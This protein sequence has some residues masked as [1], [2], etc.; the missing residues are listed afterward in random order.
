[1]WLET[2]E[3]EAARRLRRRGGQKGEDGQYLLSRLMSWADVGAF[4]SEVPKEQWYLYGEWV[5]MARSHAAQSALEEAIANKKGFLRPGC[6]NGPRLAELT[7]ALLGAGYPH[8]SPRLTEGTVGTSKNSDEEEAV[9]LDHKITKPGRRE[10]FF[11][12]WYRAVRYEYTMHASRP[13]EAHHNF[14][15]PQKFVYAVI[16]MAKGIVEDTYARVTPAEVRAAASKAAASH[17]A[18]ASVENDVQ[19]GKKR[20]FEDA[21]CH[22][23]PF[24]RDVLYPQDGNQNAAV[25]TFSLA[26][27]ETIPIFEKE[28]RHAEVR[29]AH[30]RVPKP[31]PQ[32]YQ[33][34]LRKEFPRATRRKMCAF[35]KLAMAAEKHERKLKALMPLWLRKLYVCS[36]EPRSKPTKGA[37]MKSKAGSCPQ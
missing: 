21:F 19:S 16:D 36:L 12:A 31:F 17:S 8:A 37:G 20:Q 24:Y 9:W 28:V 23:L 34:F 2:E 3:T 7:A 32:I 15:T 26:D 27:M 14:M 11:V 10:S 35:W 22:M 5:H 6:L 1:M 4:G 33:N 13:G 18:A 29:H 30:A 25:A